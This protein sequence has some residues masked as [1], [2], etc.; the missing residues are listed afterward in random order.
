[1]SKRLAK[2]S[3]DVGINQLECQLCPHACRLSD[4]QE[5]YCGVRRN[6]QGSMVLLNYGEALL[7]CEEVIETDGTFH[8]LPGSRTLAVGN[9]GC[10]LHC[11]FCQNWAFSHARERYKEF[12]RK[13]SPSDIVETALRRG[14]GII[15]WTYNEPMIWHEFI[16]DTAILARRNGLLNLIN[17]SFFVSQ[18][19]LRQLTQVIDAFAF[20]LKSLN[21][22]YYRTVCKGWV[23]PV[24]EAAKIVHASGRHV[25]Y[26]NLMVHGINDS[27]E[28]I[29][30]LLNWFIDNIGCDV[31]LH[32]VSAH[33]DY[34]FS[35]SKRTDIEKLENARRMATNRGVRWC[36]LGNLFRHPGLN[37]H[38][39]TCRAVLVERIGLTPPKNLGIADG[40][41]SSC[42]E[43][44]PITL[45]YMNKTTCGGQSEGNTSANVRQYFWG[46]NLAIHLEIRNLSS[47]A[48]MLTCVHTLENGDSLESVV[49]ELDAREEW[50]Q[51]I[52][53]LSEYEK[54]LALRWDGKLNLRVYELKDR[55]QY[56]FAPVMEVQPLSN[57]G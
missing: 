3:R 6:D 41:C 26:K 55:A 36:Y 5:G 29:N 4:G 24:L 32:F 14:I 54:A 33:P 38:C 8:F 27:D 10:S 1:M 46:Q 28:E 48:E 39:P 40:R 47:K 35:E 12:T 50:R 56:P 20:S 22:S 53:R 23:A 13:Y 45:G 34:K 21:D 44:I 2:F 49:I 11:D 43:S 31:P 52:P 57:N 9:L 25:E 16:M 7:M 51:I 42:G 18:E 17:S 37:T 15:S 19:P 30:Q